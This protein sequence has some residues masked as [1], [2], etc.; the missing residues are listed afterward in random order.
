MNGTVL[1]KKN[2]NNDNK[3]G[4]KQV[5]RRG[6]RR[7]RTRTVSDANSDGSGRRGLTDTSQICKT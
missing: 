7:R 2:N 6:R 5:R 1:Y 3:T 4:A